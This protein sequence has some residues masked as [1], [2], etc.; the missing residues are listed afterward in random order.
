MNL[1]NINLKLIFSSIAAL[2]FL[3]SIYHYSQTRVTYK[4]FEL[5]Y[6]GNHKTSIP[7]PFKM[8]SSDSKSYKINGIIS[9]SLKSGA[10]FKI[11]PDD[12]LLSIK[13]NEKD[14]D[15]SAIPKEKLRDYNNGFEID[16][17]QYLTANTNSLEIIFFDTGGMMGMGFE[18]LSEKNAIHIILISFILLISALIFATNLRVPL[19]LLLVL[20]LAI[21]LFYFDITPSDTRAHDE[22]EHVEFAQYLSKHWLPP[23]LES[24]TGGAFFHPPFYYYTSAVV[25]KISDAMGLNTLTGSRLQQLL[26]LFYSMGFLFFGLLILE[27]LLSL[28]KQKQSPFSVKNLRKD[29][30]KI[31]P[32]SK[33]MFNVTAKTADVSFLDLKKPWL[34]LIIASLFTFWPSNIIHS[35]RIGNDP[36]LYFLLTAS[37]YYIYC[38]FDSDKF[39]HLMVG[40]IFAAL[41]ILTKANAEIMIPVIG[42][43]GLYKMIKTKRWAH[44][45]KSAILPVLLITLALAI[46]VGPG[47]LLKLQGKRDK[48]FI[49]N[50]NNVSSALQVGNNA[51]NYLWFDFKTFINEPFTSPWQDEKGRQYFWNYLS[52]TGLFGE[53]NYD[54]KVVRNAGTVSSFLFLCMFAFVILGLYHFKKSDLKR[55]NVIALS[56]FFLLAGVTYMRMTFPVN[57]DFRYI[58]PITVSFCAVY[59]LCILR[60]MKI[61]QERMAYIGS[62]LALLFTFSNIIFTL[63]I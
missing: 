20:G 56:G 9:K 51:A 22:T 42:I 61:G 19:K 46:T 10:N 25:M 39:A 21:R 4:N 26:S 45:F 37:M 57:I 6:P 55:V 38:W 17:K 50:I 16:L 18:S 40:S 27:K 8:G 29:I 15:L 47:L 2:L 53:F 44:Y 62:I 52:K 31:N 23:P 34:Y 5:T 36:C 30:E 14:V 43:V 7:F 58:S 35:V 1:R 3:L 63:S 48:L 41:A 12:E 49:D 32:S 33:P 13:I 54:G 59:A 11:V 24:A 28:D 60:Y